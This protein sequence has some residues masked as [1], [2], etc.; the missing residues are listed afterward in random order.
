MIRANQGHSLKIIDLQLLTSKRLT[1]DNED[2]VI[3]VHGTFWKH[4]QNIYNEGLLAGG[5]N[6]MSKRQMI[7]FQLVNRSV[8]DGYRSEGLRTDCEVMVYVNHKRAIK[9]GIEFFITA[10]GSVV[11]KGLNGKI[12]QEYIEYIA[13]AL[14]HEAS[15]TMTRTNC[16]EDQRVDKNHWRAAVSVVS[17]IDE[18]VSPLK[19]ELDDREPWVLKIMRCTQ[20]AILPKRAS[21]GA[22][23]YDLYSAEDNSPHNHQNRKRKYANKNGP[24]NVYA[25]R[26]VRKNS[27]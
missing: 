23:G 27:P 9:D 4:V 11:S 16:R 10:N 18:E 5:V 8:A 25:T 26:S 19:P 3:C 22:A 21:E 20:S 6:D 17:K 12:P 24:K 1:P 14:Q 13:P 7:H 15:D 2:D